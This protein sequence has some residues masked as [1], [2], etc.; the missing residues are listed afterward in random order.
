MKVWENSKKLWKHSP[1]ARVST[2]FLVLPNSNSCFYNSIETQCM[3]LIIII[4]IVSIIIIVIIVIIITIVIIIIIL[5]TLLH[6]IGESKSNQSQS[7]Q[8]HRAT[9]VEGERSHHFI[10]APRNVFVGDIHMTY[11]NEVRHLGYG[12]TINFIKLPSIELHKT[13]GEMHLGEIPTI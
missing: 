8:Q 6:V 1:A 7:N 13:V 10:P 9:L 11:S 5:I 4:F 12:G 3:I 2:A